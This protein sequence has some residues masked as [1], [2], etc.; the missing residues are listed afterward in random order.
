[1][2]EI[3][4][5]SCLLLNCRELQSRLRLDRRR[6]LRAVPAK[7]QRPFCGKQFL[8]LFCCPSRSASYIVHFR[9]QPGS[10]LAAQ[11]IGVLVGALAFLTF[12]AHKVCTRSAQISAARAFVARV[13]R[14][15]PISVPASAAGFV[16]FFPFVYRLWSLRTARVVSGHS[17]CRCSRLLSITPRLCRS[18]LHSRLAPAVRLVLRFHA[19]CCSPK[20]LH[21]LFR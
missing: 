17:W 15:Q 14:I 18:V 20:S 7:E 19:C 3:D 8:F 6:P 5:C 2:L 16:S 9:A 11:F 21:K 4:H 12:S 10:I 13:G 1:M